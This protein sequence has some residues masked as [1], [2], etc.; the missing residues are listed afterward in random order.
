MFHV[1]QQNTERGS[2]VEA[3]RDRAEPVVRPWRCCWVCG[4]RGGVAYTAALRRAG[5]RMHAQQIAYAHP[6]CLA[7]A[8]WEHAERRGARLLDEERSA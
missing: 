6:A 5:Y 8:Q 2:A 1:E 3:W 7:R 4:V